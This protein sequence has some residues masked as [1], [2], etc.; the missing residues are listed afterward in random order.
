MLPLPLVA[1]RG[2]VPHPLRTVQA[3]VDA[4]SEPALVQC[5][6]APCTECGCDTFWKAETVTVFPEVLILCLNRWA[7]PTA[8]LLHPVEVTDSITFRGVEYNL[9]SVLAH[10]GSSA[11]GGHDITVAKHTTANGTWWLYD[12]EWR[13]EAT[14]NQRTTLCKYGHREMKSYVVI[15]EK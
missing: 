6:S 2:G 3:A 12:D 9:R 14:P 4:Y 15:Y 7:D 11:D 10:L 1:V 5:D 8:P 13:K